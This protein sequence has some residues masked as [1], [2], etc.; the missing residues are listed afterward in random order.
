MTPR[1]KRPEYMAWRNMIARCENPKRKDF[2]SYGGRGIKVCARWRSSFGAFLA[3]IGTRPSPQHSIDR[4]DNDGN[5]E[6]DN[7]S[8]ATKR[9]QGENRRTTTAY[10]HRGKTQSLKQ[11]SRD[12]GIP[13]A[14]LWSRI[15][16]GWPIGKALETPRQPRGGVILLTHGGDTLTLA[17]WSERLGVNKRTLQSRYRRGWPT[18]RILGV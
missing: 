17:E 2:A 14:T 16:S 18:A 3:D 9:Q 12:L 13:I 4:E 5:Y 1:N 11:W 10:T 6:P 15:E 8:W 7:V